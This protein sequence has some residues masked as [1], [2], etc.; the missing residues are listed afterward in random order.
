MKKLL[1][2]L[3]LISAFLVTGYFY[4]FKNLFTPTVVKKVKGTKIEKLKKEAVL[5]EKEF[6]ENIASSTKAERAGYSYEKLGESY[7]KNKDWTP[8]VESLEKAI[9]YGRSGARVHYSLGV[10]YANRARDLDDKEDIKK[11]ESHYK[12]AVEKNP[13]MIDASYGLAIL[14][15]YLKKD[16][17]AAI[18]MAKSIVAADPTYYNGRFALARMYYE[19]GD[20]AASLS[21]YEDLYDALSKEEDSPTIREYREN[22]RDN[23]TR[24]MA[25]L[26]GNR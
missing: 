14:T 18:G 15:Y 13:A 1:F 5:A 10:A 12:R 3:L 24:L 2:V 16:R 7:L 8:A 26:S 17:E 25:E 22:C 23:I 19:N 6:M 4:G 9:E 21:V 20:P 11:A